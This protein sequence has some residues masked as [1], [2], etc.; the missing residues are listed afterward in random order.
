[1]A[2]SVGQTA[3]VRP[4]TRV[5][6]G[7]TPGFTAYPRP[8]CFRGPAPIVQ[9]PRTPPFQGGN[10]DSNSPGVTVWGRGEVWSSRQPVKLEVAGS[11]PVAPAKP[12]SARD[13]FRA[14]LVR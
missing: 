10:G 11:N 4:L 3:L 5:R 9:R 14:Q 1:M 7:Y 12:I 6:G 13:S 2:L 8:L